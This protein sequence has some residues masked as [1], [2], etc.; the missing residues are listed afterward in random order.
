MFIWFR[1]L[2][3]IERFGD[4]KLNSL[5][6]QVNKD[7]GGWHNNKVMESNEQNMASLLI[8][9]MTVTFL[10]RREREKI[11]NSSKFKLW[12]LVEDI[13]GYHSSLYKSTP[14]FRCQERIFRWE[15]TRFHVLYTCVHLLFLLIT[16]FRHKA[17]YEGSCLVL[18]VF[19]K[20]SESL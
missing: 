6:S 7:W 10:K 1:L 19:R 18:A 3:G 13:R 4:D 15:K 8:C 2:L 17:V 11:E 12:F 14:K 9:F 20:N 16:P 5:P